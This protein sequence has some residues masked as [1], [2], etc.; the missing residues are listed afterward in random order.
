MDVSRLADQLWIVPAWVLIPLGL[1]YLVPLLRLITAPFAWG[2]RPFMQLNRLFGKWE[3][4]VGGVRELVGTPYLVGGLCWNTWVFARWGGT[5]QLMR[6]GVATLLLLAVVLFRRARHRSADD[7]LRFARANPLVHPQEFFDHLLCC[8]G[9]VRHALS[10]IAHRTIDPRAIDFRDGRGSDKPLRLRDKLAGCWSTVRLSRLALRA[11]DAERESAREMLSALAL[12][13]ATRIAQLVRAAVTVE[14]HEQLPAPG[15][16][17]LFLFTHGSFLDFAFA[18][19]VLAARPRDEG[20]PLRALPS[21]LLAEDHFRRNPILYRLLG[22]GR[23]AEQAGMLFVERRREGDD[24]AAVAERAQRITEEAARMLVEEGAELALF[25]QGT[26]A[27]PLRGRRGERLDAAYYTVGPRWRIRADNR[28]LKRGAAHI[29]VEATHALSTQKTAGGMRVWVAPIA[30]TGAAMAAPRGSMRLLPNV[31]IRLRIGEPLLLTRASMATRNRA[32]DV[33]RI[34]R[35]IDDAL[36]GVGR[37]HAELERRLFEDVRDTLD[38]LQM[39]EFSIA[40][41]PWRGEDSLVHATLDA[42][43]ACPPKHWRP[44][45]GELIHL[46]LNFASRD[47]LLAFKGRVADAVPL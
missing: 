26:R 32:A 40:L 6:I 24:E 22:I 4:A 38:A 23:V 14:R 17:Q 9:A 7:L 10:D 3:Y 44:F 29:A 31:H 42:I 16:P 45:L 21:F 36:K 41:K 39:E 46:L 11:C 5:H 33:D 35:W 1:L 43:Y 20:T 27:V 34:H 12:I 28:H 37:V 47:E 25:P 2:W 15:G 30:I 8:S 13:W 19:L 18:A